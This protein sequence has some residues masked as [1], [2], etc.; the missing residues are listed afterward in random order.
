MTTCD[1]HAAKGWVE[2]AIG[3]APYFA[4]AATTTARV[5]INA[6][7][8]SATDP[9]TFVLVSIWERSSSGTTLCGPHVRSHSSN[10]PGSG[11]ASTS[12]VPG[13]TRKNSSS[14]PRVIS[15]SAPPVMSLRVA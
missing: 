5:S 10:M 6:A 15:G 12:R 2:A 1:R 7:R 3:A 9:Q 11:S 14:T 4:A 13:S 8:S